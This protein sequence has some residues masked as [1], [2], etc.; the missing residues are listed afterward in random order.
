MDCGWEGLESGHGLLQSP[1]LRLRSVYLLLDLWGGE[2]SQVPW[3]MVLD[4]FSWMNA[5]IRCGSWKGTK[6][7]AVLCLCGADITLNY[8][9]LVVFP[10]IFSWSMTVNSSF[11]IFFSSLHYLWLL[12][13]SLFF[14]PVVLYSVFILEVFLKYVV[15]LGCTFWSRAF[16]CSL[17]SL[18]CLWGL[19]TFVTQSVTKT[20]HCGCKMSIYLGV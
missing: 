8:L 19:P 1:Q 2:T 10:K 13:R 14:P 12:L 18:I 7:R 16:K 4:F 9:I 3:C 20:F 15:V 17:G 5:E 6:M 11:H